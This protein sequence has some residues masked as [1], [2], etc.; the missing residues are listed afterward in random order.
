MP[1]DIRNLF[2]QKLPAAL[3]RHEDEARAINATYQLII[4]GAGEWF[5][6]LTARGPKI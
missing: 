3:A 4:T 2:E 6:D 5:L 1:L